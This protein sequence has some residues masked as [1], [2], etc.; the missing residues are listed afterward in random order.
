[1]GQ[2]LHDSC[3]VGCL[4]LQ[5][6]HRKS[7]LGESEYRRSSCYPELKHKQLL[8][9]ILQ[10]S[11]RKLWKFADSSST[12]FGIL[13]NWVIVGYLSLYSLWTSTWARQYISPDGKYDHIFWYNDSNNNGP[14]IGQK[15]YVTRFI[16]QGFQASQK[17]ISL[18]VHRKMP[19]SNFQGFHINIWKLYM[20]SPNAGLPFYFTKHTSTSS[21]FSCIGG[22]QASAFWESP[23]QRQWP[24][25]NTVHTTPITVLNF[26][27]SWAFLCC[28]MLSEGQKSS[29][30][31]LDPWSIAW[32]LVDR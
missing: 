8:P 5:C 28:S 1:M 26:I 25:W 13:G 16:T 29:E 14:V 31:S 15:L 4:S 9:L 27:F 2:Y 18:D 19:R 11:V 20:K 32:Y 23:G 6:E 3:L 17:Y 21:D 22:P 24:L 30:Y 10:T 12:T 7:P